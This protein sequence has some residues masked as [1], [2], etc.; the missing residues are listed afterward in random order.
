MGMRSFLAKVEAVSPAVRAK[1]PKSLAPC[2]ARVAAAATVLAA[3]LAIGAAGPASALVRD[4]GDEPG[5]TLTV[6]Q[7]L[8]LFAGI[9]IAMVLLIVA[10]VAIPS[11]FRQVRLGNR[12]NWA[13]APIWVNGPSATLEA[14]DTDDTIMRAI[15]GAQEETDFIFSGYIGPLPE[16][17][18]SIEALQAQLPY[19]SRTI[20]IATD[21]DRRFARVVVGEEAALWCNQRAREMAVLAV[22][23][24]VSVGDPIGGVR[25]AIALL[26]DQSQRPAIANETAT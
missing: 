2:K 11:W 24:A 23:S 6:A 13:E 10:A 22:M 7:T 1:Q 3:S 5:A 25:D 17:D 9:P 8:L 18:Q 16:A 26:G 12:T 4:D 19:P 20:F 15:R 14:Y 21:P